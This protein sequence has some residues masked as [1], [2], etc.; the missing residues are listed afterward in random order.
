M[1]WWLNKSVRPEVAISQ[2][3]MSEE[4][5]VVGTGWA[6]YSQFLSKIYRLLSVIPCL[7][8]DMLSIAETEIQK[9]N[10]QSAFE[11][12]P[13]YLRNEVTWEKLPHKQ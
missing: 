2:F 5:V 3:Q 10:I 4:T 12:E 11:I 9:G 8:A 13:V 1:K 6:A 7:P